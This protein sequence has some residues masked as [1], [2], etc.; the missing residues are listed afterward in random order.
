MRLNYYCRLRVETYLFCLSLLSTGV[1]A[2][3]QTISDKV[4]VHV[5]VS[6]S[7]ETVK[8][9]FEKIE[10]QT[11]YKVVYSPSTLDTSIA[12]RF[13]SKERELEKL[14]EDIAL[15]TGSTYNISDK[16]ITFKSQYGI[17]KAEKVNT[18]QQNNKTVLKGVVKDIHG[19][20]LPGATVKIK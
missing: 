14:L 15:R 11:T 12:L 18:G 19:L 4:G 3:N 8:S 13:T 1:Y 2:T 7:S 10:L 9:L 16:F 6:N 20:A 17:P 5:Y